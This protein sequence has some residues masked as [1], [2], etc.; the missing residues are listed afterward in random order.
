MI[1]ITGGTGFVGQEV[2]KQFV[3][4]GHSVRVLARDVEKAQSILGSKQVEVVQG[5][6]LETTTLKKAFQ[7]VRAVVHLVGI[8][9]EIRDSSFEKIHVQGTRN[10]VTAAKKASVSRFLHVSAIGTREYAA[11]NYHKSKWQAEELIRKSSLP[12]TIFRPSLI[13]GKHDSFSNLFASL[14]DFP[15]N[16]AAKGTMPCLGDGTNLFQ[17]VAVEEVASSILNALASEKAH[18]KTY[19]VVGPSLEFQEMLCQIA[20]AKGK[21]PVFLDCAPIAQPFIGL[22]NLMAGNYPIVIPVAMPLCRIGVFIYQA[23]GLSFLHQKLLEL[24]FP[25]PK[26]IPSEDQLTMLEESQFGDSQPLQEDLG[27]TTRPFAEG[28]KAY[29]F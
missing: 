19:D 20:K 27:I 26:L 8:I 29:L 11:S 24:E 12:W 18:L 21:K 10:V 3:D 14:L 9:A 23:L 1:L 13:Y 22:L 4:A 7:D 5:D 17:P 25:L 2:V 28:I 6:I 16:I 15:F